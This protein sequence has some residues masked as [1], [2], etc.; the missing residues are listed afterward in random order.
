MILPLPVTLKRFFAPL[1][2]FCL[3]M[4]AVVLLLGWTVPRERARPVLRSWACGCWR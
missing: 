4:A 2:V 3:G 1:C